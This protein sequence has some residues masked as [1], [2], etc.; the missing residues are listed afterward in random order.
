MALKKIV[1]ISQYAAYF[2]NKSVFL[3]PWLVLTMIE[4]VIFDLATAVGYIWMLVAGQFVIAAL[5]ITIGFLTSCLICHFW[6]AH[7]VRSVYHDIQEDKYAYPPGTIHGRQIFFKWRVS[8][9]RVGGW[10]GG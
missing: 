8:H 3:K 5:I 6:T 2:K 9:F 7:V 4:L 10:G 1:G